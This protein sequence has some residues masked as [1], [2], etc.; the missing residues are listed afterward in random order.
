M[1]TLLITLCLASAPVF[2]ATSLLVGLGDQATPPYKRGDDRLPDRRPGLAVELL[3]LAAANCDVRLQFKLLPGVRMLKE[4]ESSELDGAALLSYTAER[5]AYAMFPMLN[6]KPVESQRLATLSYVF[7]VR[8]DHHLQWH[9]SILQGLVRKVGTNFGWSINHDLDKLGIPVEPANS[10]EQNFMKLQAGRIDAYATH[11]LLGD[12]Y[13]AIHN[14]MSLVKLLPPVI[15]KAYYL[16][17][18]RNHAGRYPV[19]TSCMWRQIGIQRERLYQQR[20]V[21]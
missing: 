4:L 7:Y 17:F 5:A 13:L 14:D 9:G 15:S 3:Q 19:V 11:E 6:G 1:K 20:M 10:V 8:P 12:S 2:A 18:S 21:D 16:L